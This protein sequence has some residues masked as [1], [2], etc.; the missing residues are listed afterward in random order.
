MIAT[1]DDYARFAK[2]LLGKGMFEGKWILSEK[3]VTMMTTNQLTPSQ[4]YGYTEEK[5]SI[6]VLGL[7]FRLLR[8]RALWARSLD[9]STGWMLGYDL[10]CPS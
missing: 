9:S 1:I 6:M 7:G 10:D 3:L 8:W 2:M 5:R 4:G